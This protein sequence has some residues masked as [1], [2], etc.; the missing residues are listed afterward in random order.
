M[1][2]FNSFA[3]FLFF[4]VLFA[5]LQGCS[6]KETET[7]VTPNQSLYVKFFNDSRSVV[8]LY[9]LS[10]MNMGAVSSGKTSLKPSDGAWSDNLLSNGTTIAPGGYVFFTLNI[11]SG[12]YA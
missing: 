8:S 2:N 7:P 4:L 6:E 9:S 1:K 12:H 3:Q 11:P 5:L 10:V